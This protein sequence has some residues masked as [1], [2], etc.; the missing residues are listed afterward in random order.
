MSLPRKT[1]HTDLEPYCELTIDV[2]QNAHLEMVR[3]TAIRRLMDDIEAMNYT[4]HLDVVRHT[5]EHFAQSMGNLVHH[6]YGFPPRRPHIG[7]AARIDGGPGHRG[8]FYI[9]EVNQRD[10]DLTVSII[11]SERRVRVHRYGFDTATGEWIFTDAL[12]MNR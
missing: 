6:Y 12:W 4:T 3:E 7:Q 8:Q 2:H 5:H 9:D 10:A 11:G 1:L